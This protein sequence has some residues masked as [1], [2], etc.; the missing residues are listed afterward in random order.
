MTLCEGK[1]ASQT[2]KATR[3]MIPFIEHVQKRQTQRWKVDE[4]M[5]EHGG[6]GG[7]MASDC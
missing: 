1:E 6:A 3:S 4:W 7:G 2:Q 5:P